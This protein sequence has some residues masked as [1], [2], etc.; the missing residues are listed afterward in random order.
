MCILEGTV[1]RAV[2]PSFWVN[3][4]ISKLDQLSDYVVSDLRFRSEVSRFKEKVKAHEI[5]VVR[6][7]RYVEI[8]TEDPSE[9]DLDLHKFD[10]VMENTGSIKDLEDSIK[11]LIF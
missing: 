3:G 4:V 5:K 2:D 7:V 6:V 8:D 1:R 10:L 9:R 11:K